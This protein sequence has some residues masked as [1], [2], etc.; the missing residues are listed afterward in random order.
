MSRKPDFR[1][2]WQ[3]PPGVSRATWDYVND[4]A[5]ADQYDAF[6]G[7]HPLLSLDQALIFERLKDIACDPKTPPVLLD[8]GCG[9]GRALLPWRQRGWR[10]LGVDLSREMLAETSRKLTA[11]DGQTALVHANL[12]QSAWLANQ[13]VD[14]ALCLYSSIGMIRGRQH[15]QRLLR[16]V[17]AAL[18]PGG[19]FI[20]HVHNRSNWLTT[21]A[22]LAL[23]VRSALR[24]SF[25]REFEMGDRIY[26]YRGLPAMFLHI[27]TAGELRYELK[28]AGFRI[29]S[30]FRLNATSS[31]AL[32][33]PWFFPSIRAGGYIAFATPTISGDANAEV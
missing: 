1:P 5:I 30:L 29:E 2:T 12:A 25:D 10:T 15:R 28:R 27:F 22:G 14:A 31:D 32:S 20:L 3:L 4:R 33:L 17:A 6:H 21:P 24:A 16:A 11:V 13:S 8:L 19:I 9:T 7:D 26:P 18:K 23:F